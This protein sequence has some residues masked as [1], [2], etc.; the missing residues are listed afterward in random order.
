MKTFTS[1]FGSPLVLFLSEAKP[2]GAGY[3]FLY[4]MLF[5]IVFIF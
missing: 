4:S 1:I 5:N 3:L 2:V